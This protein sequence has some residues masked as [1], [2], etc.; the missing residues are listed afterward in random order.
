MS[1]PLAPLSVVAILVILAAVVVA[2]SRRF[3]AIGAIVIANLVVF[4]LELIG[5]PDP[6][7]PA[8]HATSV[9]A[10]LS[11]NASQFPAHPALSAL[12]MVTSMFVHASIT[13]ILGNMV[14][15]LLFA[16][17]FEERVGGR[18]FVAI[19]LVAGLVGTVTQSLVHEGESV[20]QLGASGAVAGIIGAFAAMY[21]NLRMRL[22]LFV[23]PIIWNVRVW[24]AACLAV[25]AQFL[26][27]FEDS[28]GHPTVIVGYYAHLGGLLFGVCLG[29]MLARLGH[30]A[31][32]R[33]VSVDLKRLAPFARDAGSRNAL[34]RMAHY[35]T[36]PQVFQAWLERFLRSATCPTC[37]QKVT[38][39]RDGQMVCTQGHRFD[40]RSN[41][42]QPA[43]NAVGKAA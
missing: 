18:A 41:Q 25:L 43:A 31:R 32:H 22:P 27:M 28:V 15:L 14:V 34:D 17:P 9:L 35:Q 10:Q 3:L 38:P 2:W 23:I 37:S 7:V 16:L 33:P 1:V 20:F 8:E 36:E 26:G 13:H 4:V 30:T 12:Q 24:V 5:S 40:V 6:A 21:P 42:P 29:V 19:Y 11:F 39:Q